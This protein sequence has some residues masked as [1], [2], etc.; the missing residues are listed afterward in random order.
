MILRADVQR[1]RDNANRR[2]RFAKQTYRMYKDMVPQHTVAH[3][4]SIKMLYHRGKFH[5][6]DPKSNSISYLNR[7]SE[8]SQLLS[9]MSMSKYGLSAF[10]F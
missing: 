2:M 8:K 3:R 1:L 10:A 9:I 5:V 4:P 6:I 7:V